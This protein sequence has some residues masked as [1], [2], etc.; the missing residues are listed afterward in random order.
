[1]K[2]QLCKNETETLAKSHIYPIGFFNKIKTKGRIN[3]SKL[4]GQKGRK[5]QKAIYD[6]EILCPNCETKIAVYDDYA[7][8]IFRDKI[9][10]FEVSSPQ[11]PETKLLLFCNIDKRK[12]R[13]FIASLLWRMSKSEQMEIAH[14]SIGEKYE[15]LIANEIEN[16]GNFNYVDVFSMFLKAP[17][18]SAFFS[19]YKI[20]IDPIDIKRDSQ[21]VNGWEITLPNLILRT[22]LDKRSNPLNH[23]VN[24]P[25]EVTGK[26]KN[27]NASTSLNTEDDYHFMFISTDKHENYTKKIH[28]AYFN[29]QRY[30]K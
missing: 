12:L 6:T 9:Y 11:L 19:P 26:E 1:M 13:G 24:L 15:Q 30:N 3:T 10:S 2:C 23:Y 27:I 22:S 4:D 20:K 18:H 8:K 17:H 14:I 28:A 29:K 16:E 21:A 25:P 7:I 5:L